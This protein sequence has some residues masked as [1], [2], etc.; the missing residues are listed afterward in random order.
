M[1]PHHC[2]LTPDAWHGPLQAAQ[3]AAGLVGLGHLQHCRHVLGTQLAVG[4]PAAPRQ[5]GAYCQAQAALQV[6]VLQ[7]QRCPG[8][9]RR[10]DASAALA[11]RV[12]GVCG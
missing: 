1:G 4:R 8:R 7:Q 10:C 5:A 12:G 2:V 11:G 9:A 3:A 6:A